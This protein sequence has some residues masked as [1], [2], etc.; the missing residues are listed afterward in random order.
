MREENSD[1]LS[2]KVSRRSLDSDRSN[3]ARLP[4]EHHG[5]SRMNG[6]MP[7]RTP[8]LNSAGSAADKSER[9][10]NHARRIELQSEEIA[11]LCDDKRIDRR[12]FERCVG[13]CSHKRV[14]APVTPGALSSRRPVSTSPRTASRQHSAMTAGGHKFG[15][16]CPSGTEFTLP[17][18]GPVATERSLTLAVERDMSPKLAGCRIAA[19]TGLVNLSVGHLPTKAPTT[20]TAKCEACSASCMQETLVLRQVVRKK[21]EM[22][23]WRPAHRRTP[24]RMRQRPLPEGG[25]SCELDR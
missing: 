7:R 11:L 5:H 9:V 13:K 15:A 21:C 10:C 4:R 23:S 22:S 14:A 3:P 8:S 25:A 18:P 6:K 19:S 17:A 2:V 24:F 12:P 16:H 1:S 20:S